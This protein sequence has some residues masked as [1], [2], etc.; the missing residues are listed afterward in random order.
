MSSDL[1]FHS[2]AALSRMLSRGETNSRAIVEACLARIAAHDAHLHAFVDVYRDDALAD[3]DVADRR[4]RDFLPDLQAGWLADRPLSGGRDAQRE[5][6]WQQ[7][8]R[9]QGALG[10]R[11]G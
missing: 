10:A 9:G 6:G 2:L 4:R 1:P 8:L 7:G 5:S 11:R 3:A